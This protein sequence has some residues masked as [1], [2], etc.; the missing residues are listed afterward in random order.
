MTSRFNRESVIAVVAGVGI[1]VHVCLRTMTAS[2]P[3]VLDVPLLAVLALG[4]APLVYEL[5][6]KALRREF[7]MA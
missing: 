6:V 7:G 4:G 1:A 5:A 3:A 2:A